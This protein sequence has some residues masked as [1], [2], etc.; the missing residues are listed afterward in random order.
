MIDADSFGT[1]LSTLVIIAAV[2]LVFGLAIL[3]DI[4]MRRREDRAVRKGTEN[5]EVLRNTADDQGAGESTSAEPH[6]TAGTE[7]RGRAN[8]QLPTG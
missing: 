2:S 6:S 1:A 8:G 3:S 7:S 5:G 4:A